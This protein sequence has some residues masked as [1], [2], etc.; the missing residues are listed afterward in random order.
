MVNAQSGCLQGRAG[1]YF[2]YYLSMLKRV[3][4]VVHLQWKKSPR[5]AGRFNKTFALRL[6]NHSAGQGQARG[7]CWQTSKA[8]ARAT[9]PPVLRAPITR[10]LK[11]LLI[12]A[13]SLELAAK[14]RCL[15][16]K[17]S[18]VSRVTSQGEAA[19]DGSPAVP[20][21]ESAAGISNTLHWDRLGKVALCNTKST[22]WLVRVHFLSS[23]SEVSLLR[24]E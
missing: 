14:S 16:L 8:A 7:V 6:N 4:G 24:S 2:A 15:A 12:A 1:S 21:P 3:Q 11:A 19:A 5:E 23:E 22:A 20:G 13:S 17:I 18:A 10:T 9:P